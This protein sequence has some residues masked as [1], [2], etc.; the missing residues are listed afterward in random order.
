MRRVWDVQ[1]DARLRSL[2]LD[3]QPRSQIAVLMSMTEDAVKLRIY[4]L[5]FSK[6]DK[7]TRRINRRKF[8]NSI[9]RT[10]R[11]WKEQ[12]TKAFA[13]CEMALADRA[14]RAALQ[15]RSVTAALCGDPLPGYSAL[16][17]RA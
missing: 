10:M 7:A 13:P 6:D 17:R 1:T 8:K 16:E 14:H 5:R 9:L 2:Y 15:P 3:G 12:P 4:A 11:T